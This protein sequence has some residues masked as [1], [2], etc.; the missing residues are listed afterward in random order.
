M[1]DKQLGFRI[2][3]IHISKTNPENAINTITNAAISGQGG[4]FACLICE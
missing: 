4:I 1:K 2:G 3:N